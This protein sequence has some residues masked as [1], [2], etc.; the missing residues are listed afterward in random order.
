MTRCRWAARGIAAERP[1]ELHR[2]VA[3]LLSQNRCSPMHP[4]QFRGLG[5]DSPVFWPPVRAVK[6]RAQNQGDKNPRVVIPL[7]GAAGLPFSGFYDRM[8]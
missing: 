5:T 4:G 2:L 6:K 1:Q 8:G 3:I 7:S